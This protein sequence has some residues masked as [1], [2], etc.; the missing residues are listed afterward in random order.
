MLDSKEKIIRLAVGAII[1]IIGIIR[2]LT[3]GKTID[4]ASFGAD[5]YTYTYKGIVAM[6]KLLKSIE[7]TLGWILVAIGA[8][9]GLKAIDSD[10]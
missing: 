6:V 1:I 7:V 9:I 2:I 10:F 5:F 3:A 4:T 8:S